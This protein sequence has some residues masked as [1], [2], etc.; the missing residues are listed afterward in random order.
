MSP[1]RSKKEKMI[2][3]KTDKD[4][5]EMSNP[6]DRGF[7]PDYAF[8]ASILAH[9]PIGCTAMKYV[10]FDP[11]PTNDRYVAFAS[12][13]SDRS[14][15]LVSTNAAKI[16]V[17][18]VTTYG[19]MKEYL[20]RVGARG[21][22]LAVMIDDSRINS[23]IDTKFTRM[24]EASK[25][26]NVSLLIVKMTGHVTTSSPRLFDEDPFTK[27]LYPDSHVYVLRP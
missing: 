10:F 27:F 19:S 7:P 5:I 13:L 3:R 21:S 18:C 6:V 22:D 2:S 11:F 1:Y 15:S 25:G 26:L 16:F 14:I 8:A 12:L 4:V 24:V 23:P 9:V 17:R 20:E